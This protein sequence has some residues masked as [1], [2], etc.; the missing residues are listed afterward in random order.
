DSVADGTI[1]QVDRGGSDVDSRPTRIAVAGDDGA[2]HGDRRPGRREPHAAAAARAGRVAGAIV[3]DCAKPHC[4]APGQ[5]SPTRRRSSPTV[6]TTPAPTAG[7]R[8]PRNRRI[9]D[10]HHRRV[11][12][13]YA[14]AVAGAIV[15]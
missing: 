11:G 10:E 9:L 8:I 13:I 14:P 12:V 6:N 7:R 1:T 15:P 4:E 5:I 2:L 3:R